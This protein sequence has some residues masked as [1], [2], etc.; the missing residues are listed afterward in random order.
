MYRFREHLKNMATYAPTELLEIVTNY[1]VLRQDGGRLLP[2]ESVIGSKTVLYERVHR[3]VVGEQNDRPIL[4]LEFGVYE[5][6]SIRRWAG[7]TTH[8]ESRFVRFDSFE[9]LPTK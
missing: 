3:L 4:F 5:G 7:L 9:G 8:P 1:S 2:P 6:N